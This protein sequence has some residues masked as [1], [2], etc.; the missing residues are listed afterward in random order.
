MSDFNSCLL[1]GGN[2]EKK[3]VNLDLWVN[4]SLIVIESVP[5][6]AC[7]SCGEET[8]DPEVSKQIDRIAK[9]R[10]NPKKKIT[11]PVFSLAA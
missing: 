2:M 3:L 1:C 6:E 7:I 9:T 8:F 5:T 10:K 4:N 11:I